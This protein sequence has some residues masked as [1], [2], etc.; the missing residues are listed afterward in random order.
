MGTASLGSS[1]SRAVGDSLHTGCTLGP[2]WEYLLPFTANIRSD[3]AFDPVASVPGVKKAG[4]GV[5]VGAR[6][7]VAKGEGLPA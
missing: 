6:W 4:C 5:R 1:Y 7:I 2:R 3:A